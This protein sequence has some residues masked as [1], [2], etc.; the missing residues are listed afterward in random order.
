M[1]QNR[2]FPNS[3]AQKKNNG[4]S[5]TRIRDSRCTI[6]VTFILKK[7]S[8]HSLPKDTG[9]NRNLQEFYAIS[10]PP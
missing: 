6:N 8:I 4:S 10:S 1:N 7:F 5:D 9:F 2:V 3:L